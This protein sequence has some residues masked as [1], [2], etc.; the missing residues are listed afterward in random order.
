VCFLNTA[1]ISAFVG[2]SLKIE[3]EMHGTTMKI[4]YF[5]V[6]FLTTVSV[7]QSVQCRLAEL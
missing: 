4:K 6:V 5:V 3:I 1:N 2:F 7:A